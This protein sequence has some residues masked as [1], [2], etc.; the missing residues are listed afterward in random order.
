MLQSIDRAQA[1]RHCAGALLPLVAVILF[2]LSVPAADARYSRK[3]AIWG[4]T[5]VNGVSQFPIYHDLG[6]GIY[7]MQLHWDQ[8]APTR[9]EH[10][11]D[12]ADPAYRWP[13]EV[14][15][16]VRE[17]RRHYSDLRRELIGV[18]RAALL[19]LR[20]DGKLRPDV[21]RL[22]QRDLDLEEARLT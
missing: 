1:A 7:Q 10:P 22:I 15:Y 6:V 19:G 20:N 21:Q 4:P 16:A 5:Q 14:A 11:R 2:A 17:S 13:P 8:V 3:K 12:P 18:E 9:P